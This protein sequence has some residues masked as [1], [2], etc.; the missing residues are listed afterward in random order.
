MEFYGQRA[1]SVLTDLFDERNLY[2]ITDAT[3]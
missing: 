3:A 1:L 2:L